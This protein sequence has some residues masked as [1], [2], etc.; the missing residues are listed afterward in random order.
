MYRAKLG[1]QTTCGCYYPSKLWHNPGKDNV[2]CCCLDWALGKQCIPKLVE[3]QA[4]K[5]VEQRCGHMARGWMQCKVLPIQQRVL[6]CCQV[7]GPKTGPVA[8]VEEGLWL[9][10][11]VSDQFGSG[12]N[13]TP[14]F[15]LGGCNRPAPGGLAASQ[16]AV[17]CHGH[18]CMS[19]LGDRPPCATTRGAGWPA[20]EMEH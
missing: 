12:S 18:Q 16:S 1:D 17:C 8:K 2:Y 15:C 19:S 4:G 10:L 14:G 11:A 5:R 13:L 3:H 6:H 7:L 9:R 20:L